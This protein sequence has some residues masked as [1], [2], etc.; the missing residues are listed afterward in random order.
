M[1]ILLLSML[2][3]AQEAPASADN[4]EEEEEA[5]DAPRQFSLSGGLEAE[6]GPSALD[7]FEGA[8]EDTD[9][10]SPELEQALK[11]EL[12]PGLGLLLASGGSPR[13][14][15]RGRFSFRPT[16]LVTGARGDDGGQAAAGLG[17]AVL[18]R[19]WL[20]G[21]ETVQLGGESRLEAIANVGAGGYQLSLY[22]VAGT[23][24]GPVGL[25][26]GPALRLDRAEWEQASVLQEAGLLAGGRGLVSTSAGPLSLYG[27]AE[28][29]QG[30]TGDRGEEWTALAG[31]IVERKMLQVIGRFSWREAPEGA[32]WTAGLGLH[33]QPHL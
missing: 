12:P 26:V 23:W 10:M 2:A 17:G 4:G 31:G 16:V 6:G 7:D 13:S 27:G 18:H 5:T 24:L 21:T 9:E 32:L 33:I 11:D 29:A 25:H 8:V 14:M 20:L 28:L 1:V 22:S 15:L 3:R 19:W 30:L